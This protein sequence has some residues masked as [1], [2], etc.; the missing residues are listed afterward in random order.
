LGTCIKK[1][2]KLIIPAFSLGRTQEIVYVLDKLKNAKL[3]PDIKVYVDSPLSAAVTD[4]VKRHSNSY[5]ASLQAYL[6]TDPN[7]FG[8]DG[9]KYI[10][11]SGESKALNDSSEPCIIISASGMGDAG[12]VKHHIMHAISDQRNTIL[13]TGYCSPRTLGAELLAGKNKVHIY[14]DFYDVKAQ[15]ESIQSYSAHADYNELLQFLSCQQK[16][17][18][19]TVF[20]VH[21]DP[22]SKVSFREKLILSGF[23]NVIIPAK[24][25]VHDLY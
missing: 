25:E 19:K 13:L 2:G 22:G 8:F 3:L 11:E 15:I 14:G 24:G 21:G 9:L 23:M 18:V 1:K 6:K 16:D 7:P 4:V 5:N 20:L 10:Q 17:K 12:R